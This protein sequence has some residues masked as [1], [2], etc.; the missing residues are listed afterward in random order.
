MLP[1]VATGVSSTEGTAI[2]IQV[3]PSGKL[4][5][6]HT[7]A[8][9]SPNTVE[10]ETKNAPL[11]AP[12]AKTTSAA[13]KSTAASKAK[14]EGSSEKKPRQPRKQSSAS[15][16]QTKSTVKKNNTPQASVTSTSTEEESTSKGQPSSSQH[17]QAIDVIDMVSA[18]SSRDSAVFSTM[19]HNDNESLCF[20]ESD[21]D[22]IDHSDRLIS[23][24]TPLVPSSSNKTVQGQTE[25]FI[26][27]DEMSNFYV[28]PSCSR[29]SVV[30]T[31]QNRPF[32]T[33]MNINEALREA[34]G[35]KEEPGIAAAAESDSG[36]EE[37]DADVEDNIM[38]VEPSSI[39]ME[40]DHP[41]ASSA[42][43]TSPEPKDST[44]PEQQPESSG[45]RK[46]KPANFFDPTPVS[47]R[48]V[49]KSKSSPVASL[50]MEDHQQESSVEKVQ[51]SVVMTIDMTAEVAA[52]EGGQTTTVSPEE[53]AS[54][55][56]T[57]VSN[58]KTVDAQKKKRAPKPKKL[59]D[60]A[61]GEL[62]A[63]VDGPVVVT[64]TAAVVTLLP[65]QQAKVDKIIE[66]INIFANELVALER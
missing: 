38:S 31:E 63:L 2:K 40:T 19:I 51:D 35:R 34:A 13:P 16:T 11:K 20:S 5:E 17:S 4:N 56:I 47:M 10:R 43:P 15:S 60:D 37:S 33:V 59:A 1:P 46:R 50:S 22:P 25:E 65:E 39:P 36:K 53:T 26:M 28:S 29:L 23:S 24:S 12:A 18:E 30:A 41:D 66:R 32:S 57:T 58:V 44:D 21:A 42:P 45:R 8:P 64:P 9:L 55:A 54:V 52:A 48:N 14:K 7:P 6:P 61:S 3:E 62:A 49:K 27:R